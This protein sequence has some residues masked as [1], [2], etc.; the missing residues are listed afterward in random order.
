MTCP[1][2][3][4]ENVTVQVVSETQLK[5]KHHGLIY[6]LFFGWLVD[7]V[8]W[9]VLTLPMLIIAI[10]KPRRNKMKTKHKSMWLCH[11]CGH[12]WEAKA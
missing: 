12:H 8:L 1:K 3:E 7:M 11:N 6:W 5:K 9:L 2:C 4:S 10:F